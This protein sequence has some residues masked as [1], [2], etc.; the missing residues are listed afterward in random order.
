MSSEFSGIFHCIAL[1][2]MQSGLAKLWSVEITR[3][4]FQFVTLSGH[5][6]IRNGGATLYCMHLNLEEKTNIL[7]SFSRSFQSGK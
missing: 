2:D 3:E 1:F 6:R 4:T 7:I 5:S